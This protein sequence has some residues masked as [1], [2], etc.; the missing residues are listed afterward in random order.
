[1][2]LA[3]TY[4]VMSISMVYFIKLQEYRAASGDKYNNNESKTVKSKIFP[5]FLLV[6]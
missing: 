5:I 2:L 1:M 3:I 6:L 4:L